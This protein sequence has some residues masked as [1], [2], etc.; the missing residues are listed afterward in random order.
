[1][2]MLKMKMKNK[3]LFTFTIV[4]LILLTGCRS[5]LATHT[6]TFDQMNPG[7]IPEKQAIEIASAYVPPDALTSAKVTTSVGVGGGH[8]MWVIDFTLIS[9]TTIT[10]AQLSQTGWQADKNTEY[11]SDN[12]NYNQLMIVVDANTSDILSKRATQAIQLGGPPPASI[13][14]K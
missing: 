2:N 10:R 9:G 1:M 8:T 12:N 6:T 4:W 14:L 7:K 11:Y 3:L 5:A 13:T